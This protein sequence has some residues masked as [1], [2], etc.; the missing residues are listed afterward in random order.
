MHPMHARTRALWPDYCTPWFYG[1]HRVEATQACNRN[2]WFLYHVV[3]ITNREIAFASCFQIL[4]SCYQPYQ[5]K[6][7]ICPAVYEIMNTKFCSFFFALTLLLGCWTPGSECNVPFGDGIQTI[8]YRAWLNVSALWVSS[9]YLHHARDQIS[10]RPWMHVRS[11]PTLAP[12]QAGPSTCGRR[13]LS[14]T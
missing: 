5:G 14:R 4:V 6:D 10:E 11:K 1:Q 13:S 8:F 3:S 7:G 12:I 9:A 2:F